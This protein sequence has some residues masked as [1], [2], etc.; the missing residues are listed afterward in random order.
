VTG[1]EQVHRSF[2]VVYTSYIADVVI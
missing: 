1:T 2:C